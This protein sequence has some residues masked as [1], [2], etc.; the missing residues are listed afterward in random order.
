MAA[1]LLQVFSSFYTKFSINSLFISA[2]TYEKYIVSKEYCIAGHDDKM[3][4]LPNW[5]ITLS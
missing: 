2:N 1:K 4:F 3:C 5:D